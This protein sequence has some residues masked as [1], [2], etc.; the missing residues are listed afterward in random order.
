MHVL[1]LPVPPEVVPRDLRDSYLSGGL[2]LARISQRRYSAETHAA[3]DTG[4]MYAGT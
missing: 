4:K 3:F 2:L 1:A